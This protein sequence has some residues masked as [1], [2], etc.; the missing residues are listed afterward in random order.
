[1]ALYVFLFSILKRP[2]P[3]QQEGKIARFTTEHSFF[4]PQFNLSFYPC[5]SEVVKQNVL[6]E[7]AT[8][9]EMKENHTIFQ[10][11]A[12]E[13]T[14]T[15]TKSPEKLFGTMD[16]NIAVNPH[17]TN[18]L[19]I[20]STPKI[21]VRKQDSVENL[22]AAVS[23]EI[24]S[25]STPSF[26]EKENLNSTGS[27]S[28]SETDVSRSPMSLGDSSLEV[29]PERTN[30]VVGGSLAGPKNTSTPLVP[31]PQQ[32]ARRRPGRPPGSTKKRMQTYAEYR[33]KGDSNAPSA[34]DFSLRKFFE[35]GGRDYNEYLDWLKKRQA[36]QNAT[37]V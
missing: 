6:T 22:R 34:D 37:A 30:S 36:Q 5:I 1:M 26:C 8:T 25:P 20:M 32:P 15:S 23:E 28:S 9:N 24:N 10:H 21:S 4:H 3:K 16:N 31:P 18:G 11:T 33:K 7:T 14:T 13:N 17:I 12:T 29:S 19:S 35:A 27:S 2:H